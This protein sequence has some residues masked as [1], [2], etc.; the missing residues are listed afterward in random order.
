MKKDSPLRLI[1][2]QTVSYLRSQTIYHALAY[3]KK[4]RD[5]DI[6]VLDSPDAPYVCVGFHGDVHQEVN[7]GYCQQN[8]IPIIRRET[9]GGTVYIDENQLFVQWI[10]EPGHLPYRIDE[11]FKLFIDPLVE[12]HRAIGINASFHQP[13]DVQVRGKKIVGTGAARIGDAEV[14]TGNF[15]FDFDNQ[16]MADILK[17]PNAQFKLAALESLEKYMTSFSRELDNLP[18]VEDVK[19]IYLEKCRSILGREIYHSDFTEEEID[20][21]EML[22]QK[23]TANEWLYQFHSG[24]QENRL[25]KIH[26]NV[27]LFEHEMPSPK[28]K[29]GVRIRTRGK[30]IDKIS[31]FGDFV[32][33]PRHR[34]AGLANLLHNVDLELKPLTEVLEAFYAMHNI[35]DAS[36]SIQDLTDAILAIKDN[37]VSAPF[38]DR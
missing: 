14:V 28:G 35:P 8:N 23:M 31:F 30:R 33:E 38:I 22:D 16:V 4:D 1:D 10:F 5:P 9:G 21:M 13:N 37:R 18:K 2:A 7:V 12:T 24:S 29:L 34:L 32:F 11:R 19:S 17:S 25:V 15:L 6:I 20:M 3:T 26:A 36:I 27:W